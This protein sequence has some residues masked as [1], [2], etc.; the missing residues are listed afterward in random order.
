M[1]TVDMHAQPTYTGLI[2]NPSD[3]SSEDE[4]QGN[5]QY[6]KALGRALGSSNSSTEIES[7][8]DS[9]DE[10]ADDEGET[11]AKHEIEEWVAKIDR[12][13]LSIG[14]ESPDQRS[15]DLSNNDEVPSPISGGYEELEDDTSQAS[16]DEIQGRTQ[17]VMKEYDD[18]TSEEDG[19]FQD[20]LARLPDFTDSE[21]EDINSGPFNPPLRHDKG[22]DIDRS[23][24]EDHA[25]HSRSPLF[26]KD[27][28]SDLDEEDNYNQAHSPVFQEDSENSLRDLHN[29]DVDYQPGNPL[30][31]KEIQN[32]IDERSQTDSETETNTFSSSSFNR[33]DHEIQDSPSR[34]INF[35]DL[36]SETQQKIRED[37]H[38]RILYQAVCTEVHNTLARTL[39]SVKADPT[40]STDGDDILSRFIMAF[41]QAA[42]NDSSLMMDALE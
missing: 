18:S 32:E 30:F 23:D 37:P 26:R 25:D 27:I 3:D 10:D 33:D 31:R 38:F 17:E 1:S 9:E 11:V 13:D 22:D 16:G 5:L 2:P 14:M 4:I 6:E 29:T 35:K 39:E 21:E 7:S 19:D 34:S 15:P 40:I 12:N 42:E 41:K 28:E 36:K 8:L 20:Y 24:E